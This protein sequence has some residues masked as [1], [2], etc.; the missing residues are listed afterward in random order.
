MN[1]FDIEFYLNSLSTDIEE[2]DVS[3]KKI[4][5]LPDLSKF[6]KLKRLNCNYNN[7]YFLPTLHP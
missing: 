2:I 7:L 1:S 5:Y 4:N 3:Y 6:T